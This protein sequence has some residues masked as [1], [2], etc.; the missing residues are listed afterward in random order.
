MRKRRLIATVGVLLLAGAGI[1]G[2]LVTQSDPVPRVILY[3]DSL[4]VE[5]AKYVR[6]A[7]NRRQAVRFS[8]RAV[9]GSAPCDWIQRA[10]NDSAESPDAVIIEAFGNNVSAC[11]LDSKGRR[12]A[13]ETLAYWNQYRDDLHR[14]A[15]VFPP[16][17]K[18]F[19]TAAPAAYNDRSAHASHKHR[20]LIAM[21]A[22]AR[23]LDNVK[24]INAGRAVE[25]HGKY[26]RVMPCRRNEHCSNRPR[27]G[28][29]YVRSRDGLHFCP[30]ILR[31]TVEQLENCPVRASGAWRF[32]NA[33]AAP[34]VAALGLNKLS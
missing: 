19:I 34:V 8:S 5:S 12:P 16:S 33:Q 20:M 7:L 11:Q 22:A 30:P 10:L 27:F 28:Y 26:T 18:V 6:A 31:A 3:G 2:Y 4:S 14:L 1:A 9:S 21:L 13:S 25:L 24:V 32:G 15:R 17:T 29:T 23:G